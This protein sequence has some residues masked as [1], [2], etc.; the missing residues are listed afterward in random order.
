MR[1]EAVFGVD[2]ERRALGQGRASRHQLNYL[3]P[4]VELV[5]FGLTD[6]ACFR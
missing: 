6:S 5:S 4:V 2:V 1:N 3:L